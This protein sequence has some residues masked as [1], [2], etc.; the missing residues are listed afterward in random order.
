MREEWDMEFV[1]SGPKAL[2]AM[3]E[4]RFD[5]IVSDLRMPEMDG[6]QLL[7]EVMRL[8]PRAARLILTGDA[9]NEAALNCVGSAHQFLAKPCDVEALKATLRRVADL[10]CS[11]RNDEIRALVSRLT[12]IPSV[13]SLY[14][15]IVERLRSPDVALDT[16]GEIIAR[17]MGMTAK[18][19]KLVNSAFFGLPR[20]M[21]SPAEA[22]KYLGIDT[23]KTLV[24]S[25]A[26]FS[27][28]ENDELGGLSL[29]AIWDHSLQTAGIAKA[30]AQDTEAERT[31]VEE[32]FVAGLLHDIGKV[33]LAANQHKTYPT[34]L[35][36]AQ[37]ERISLAEAERLV[38]CADHAEVG[39]YLLGLWGLPIPVVEAIAWHH[40][41]SRP[42]KQSFSPLTATHLANSIASEALFA[43]SGL[44][45]NGVDADYVRRLGLT[46]QFQVWRHRL[47]S[48]R[49]RVE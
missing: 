10:D 45:T 7:N 32:S 22:V 29:R 40:S 20:R 23:I 6:A 13:P 47:N 9:N 5:V 12:K 16:I 24:L 4:R 35:R 41:P 33:V 44:R 37:S 48:G 26:A 43:S 28:F 27:Q 14:L 46:E 8:H 11:L 36:M 42:V 39:G 21:S 18:V 19:L 1:E 2:A 34:V 49:F 17:D 3:Q 25:I 31:L 30:I 38:F 15:E